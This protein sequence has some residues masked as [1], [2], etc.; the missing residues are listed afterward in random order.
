SRFCSSDYASK[1][2]NGIRIKRV[3]R[4]TNRVLI[5][6]YE[7][8]LLIDVDESDYINNKPSVRK[9]IEYLMYCWRNNFGSQKDELYHII[10]NGFNDPS[11]YK[12]KGYEEAIPFTN[13][14]YTSD[15]NRM[16]NNRKQSNSKTNN[17]LAYKNGYILLCKVYTNRII[18]H[19]TGTISPHSYQE[20]LGVKRRVASSASSYDE[21]GDIKKCDCKTKQLEWYLFDKSIALPEYIIEYE[22][23]NKYNSDNVFDRELSTLNVDKTILGNNVDSDEENNEEEFDLES[24]VTEQIHEQH[25]RHEELRPES[26]SELNLHNVGLTTFDLAALLNLKN[27]KKLIASF[28]KLTSISEIALLNNLEYLDVSYNSIRNLNEIKKITRVC[29][30]D[31]SNNK[32]Q[33]SISLCQALKTNFPILNYLDIDKNPI[34]KKTKIRVLLLY[35]LRSLSKLNKEPI[36]DSER[37]FNENKLKLSPDLVKNN[38]H[39]IFQKPRSLNYTFIT[40]LFTDES[41]QNYSFSNGNMRNELNYSLNSEL[42]FTPDVNYFEK[43]TV[44]IIERQSL[45][46]LTNIDYLVNLKYASFNDNYLTRI[47]GIDRCLK[48]EELSLENNLLQSLNGLENLENLR[49]LNVNNNEI[50]YYD[51]LNNRSEISFKNWDLSLPRLNYLSISNNNLTSIKFASK[52]PSLI[53][54]YA[55]LNKVKNLREIFHLKNLNG[56]AILDLSSNPMAFDPK[57]RLFLIYHLKILKSLDGTLIESME[58]VESKDSFGGKLTCDFIAEKFTHSR[59]CDIRSLE[60]PQCSIRLVDLGPTVEFVA[61]Q[62]ESLRSL[63]LENNNLTSFSGL[64]YLKNLKILCLNNNKIDCLFPKQ[65]SQNQIQNIPEQILPSLEVLHLA[66]NG[67]NDLVAFQIGRLTSLKA[68][69]LQGNEITKIEGLDTLRELRELVLD[70]N[71]IKAIGEYSFVGQGNRL[72]ELHMEE[73]RIRDLNNIQ[74]LKHLQKLYVANNKM[75]DYSDIEKLMEMNNLYEVSMINNPISR[76]PHY[77]IT[78]VFK[79]KRLKILDMIEVSEDDRI[80]AEIYFC[81]QQQLQQ[82]PQIYF[83]GLVQTTPQVIATQIQNQSTLNQLEN[84]FMALSQSPRLK[85]ITLLEKQYVTNP[86]ILNNNTSNKKMKNQLDKLNK[87]YQTRY[88]N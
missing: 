43:I 27:L 13:N 38:S 86:Q 77:R 26:I 32:I 10:R 28:N 14:L 52:L 46:K 84:Q 63:N 80:K 61:E 88:R 7:E 39:T 45:L 75:N 2:I 16:E 9:K 44:L 31:L 53:E 72:L 67:I 35:M 3:F 65:K 51:D 21:N 37:D 1:S 76:R 79:I 25:L 11:L 22:Y 4:V 24:I 59:L 5:A 78:M 49:K 8:K 23:L 82:Q 60:F 41:H 42:D 54:F 55:S 56:L 69:F 47:E 48:L 71:K 74:V 73:N 34:K 12:E 62:F 57:Y 87:D 18:D 15:M 20:N 50:I 33:D 29:Y 30:L 17:N 58:L 19:T 83:N 36:N 81:E 68:L 85:P 6:K 66:F 70:K 40:D 64:I